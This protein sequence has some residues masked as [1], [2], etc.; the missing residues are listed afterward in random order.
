MSSLKGKG[1]VLLSLVS[2]YFHGMGVVWQGLFILALLQDLSLYL[3]GHF[4]LYFCFCL[5]L[6]RPFPNPP[7]P[8]APRG[9]CRLRWNRLQDAKCRACR[10][11][12]RETENVSWPNFL[13]WS[14]T[15][16]PG[17][18]PTTGLLSRI[19]RRACLFP[20]SSLPQRNPLIKIT[21]PHL[22]CFFPTCCPFPGNSRGK[23]Q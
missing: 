11:P 5:S 7:R 22:R 8:W 3:P 15:S 16:G 21:S 19:H 20:S 12:S 17:S 10:A 1:I 6:F 14:A 2:G 23:I 18:T 4:F 13:A 9:T